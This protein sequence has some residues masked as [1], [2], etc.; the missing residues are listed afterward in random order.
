MAGL[1]GHIRFPCQHI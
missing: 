1:V